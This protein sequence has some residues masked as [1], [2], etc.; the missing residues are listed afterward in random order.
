[1]DSYDEIPYESTSFAE[2]HPAHLAPLVRLFGLPA[3][4]PEGCR[5]LEIGC[6]SGG[7]LIPMALDLPES[8]F[9]GIDLSAR[10]AGEG[11]G[12]IQ[13]LGLGNIEIRQGDITEFAESGGGFDYII[14]HGIYSWVPHPVRERLLSVAREQL[15]PKGVLYLSYNTLPGWRWRGILRD[16]LLFHTRNARS[17]GERLEQ[18]WQCLDF[19]ERTLAVGDH[20]TAR[21]L[22]QELARIRGNHASYLY[23]EYLESENHP[24]L[25]SDFLADVGRHGL[26]YVCDT[27]LYGMFGFSQGEAVGDWAEQQGGGM[28][29]LWQYLDFAAN[30]SFRQS[31]LCRDDRAIRDDIDLG[32]FDGYSFFTSLRP[33]RKL[34]LRKGKP[35]E[36]IRVD[37]ERCSVEH[38][39]TQ[40]ALL[41]LIDRYPDALPLDELITE[42]CRYLAQAGNPRQA[43]EVDALHGELFAL[44]S[45]Q[46]VGARLAPLRLPRGDRSRPR[47]KPLARAQLAAGMTQLA[48]A[49]HASIRLDPF[50]LRLA[51]LCDGSRTVEAITTAMTEAM[52]TDP[53]LANHLTPGQRNHP[54]RLRQAVE[55]GCRQ[56][57]ALF[58]RSGVLDRPVG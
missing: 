16:L 4:D 6:A 8:R 37:E 50:G 48:A 13:R 21:Y 35:V 38:P 39:L 32:Q 14:A 27:D 12:L 5:V 34:D 20:L 30:R 7:N 15:S 43:D 31:L 44:Y 3:V 57:I 17:A 33:P 41:I 46:C 26:R 53:V 23:H 56:L 47:L 55:E 52:A 18:A 25:F 22:R 29:A 49:H 45:R 40:A 1:M 10:Q 2:T 51:A 9:L 11:A 36:F 28:A 19:V 58:D 42:A 54:E 24:F